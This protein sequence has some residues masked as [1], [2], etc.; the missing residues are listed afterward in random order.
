V[1]D[2]IFLA[3]LVSRDAARA[4]LTS[5][6][7]L[8]QTHSLK[9]KS[10]IPH[11]VGAGEGGNSGPASPAHKR[12]TVFMNP[13][14]VALL[15]GGGHILCWRCRALLQD[16][17]DSSWG[18]PSSTRQGGQAID[19]GRRTG[20]GHDEVEEAQPAEW[21][22]AATPQPAD[23]SVTAFLAASGGTGMSQDVHL[24]LRS[25]SVHSSILHFFRSSIVGLLQQKS[26]STLRSV[27]MRMTTMSTFLH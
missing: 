18:V 10:A 26:R 16:D 20:R 2:S 23:M 27:W 15:T 3:T 9:R 11:L 19:A 12:D 8:F 1:T 25:T 21:S 7:H 17:G 4:E 22:R 14:P 13:L 24:Y 5:S 6:I